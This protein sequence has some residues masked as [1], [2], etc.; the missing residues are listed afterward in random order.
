[1]KNF[2]YAAILATT[3]LSASVI[4]QSAT[5]APV[6]AES[7]GELPAIY[8]AALSPDATEIAAVIN[9]QGKYL[10]RITDLENLSAEPRLVALGDGVKPGYIKWA[11]NGRVLLSFW[12]SEE[13]YGTPIRTGYLFTL[14]TESLKGKILVDPRKDGV[15]KSGTRLGSSSIFRQF[16]NVVV[17][18][19]EDDPDHILMSYSNDDNNNL[20]PDLRRVHVETGKSVVVKNGT[21]GIQ[22]WYTGQNG[23]VRIGQGRRDDSKASWMMRIKDVDSDKWRGS[24]EYPGLDADAS[25]YGFTSNPNELIISAYRGKDT[26]GL[27]VYD[28]SAK[29]ITRKIYHNDKYDASGVILSKGGDEIIGAR[30]TADTPETEMIGNNDTILESMRREFTGYTVDYVDQSADGGTVLFKVSSP[31]D[32]G[33][34]M[35][36]EG[37]SGK[38]MNLGAMRPSL[39]PSDLG[40]SISVRYPARDGQKIPS[41][42]TLPPTI[43]DN[44]QLK[45][46]PFIVLPHGG[47]YGRDSKRFDY[48]AQFFA[49]RGFGVLQMNFRGS[50]G[51]GKAYEEAGRKNWEIMQED[52]EDGTRWLIEKGYA[53]PKRTCI[54]GWS[55]GGYAALMGA[56]KNP[57]LY[58]CAI[59]MAG[60]TDIKD[61]MRDTREYRFGR[62]SAKKFIGS[63]FEDKDDI[64][65]NSPVKIA[66]DM[67]VPLFLAHGELDQQVRIDQFRRM[68]KALKKSDAKVTYMEF[69]NEDHYLSNQENRIKFFKGLDKFLNDNVGKSEFAP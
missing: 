22:R 12:Q 1:M 31:Y 54:A 30:Y 47:P 19:L 25:I 43:T 20:M 40:S 37:V 8:N 63:G 51:F 29:S 24:D 10:I 36:V 17:D 58:Q 56:A 32:A 18:L 11:N 6:P 28:L 9:Y 35:L 13:F 45:N 68:K 64:K 7:F 53:D 26:L 55:Y 39:S 46:L 27:Y 4:G 60:I 33:A 67:T 14:D 23:D 16:N 38:P 61:L 65:A 49:N 52:V 34:M 48:F 5:A 57:D 42:V 2:F 41:Y 44:S 21:S 3:I 15:S 50:E 62:A 59:S 66:A 69:K